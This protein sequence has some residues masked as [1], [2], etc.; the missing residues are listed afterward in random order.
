MMGGRGI[1]FVVVWSFAAMALPALADVPSVAVAVLEP[2]GESKVSGELRFTPVGTEGVRVQGTISGLSGEQAIHIHQ[3]G[4]CRAKDGT[5][6][7]PHFMAPNTHHGAPNNPGSHLGDLGN[8][9]ANK[10]G[11][12]TVDVT[13]ASISLTGEYGVLGRGVI[14]H[15]GKDDLK[16]DP[17]GNSGARVACGIIGAAK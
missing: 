11:V 4:D 2:L 8:L 13:I 5:S 7:G 14:V 16:T 12:A 10:D 6:A 15:A 17:A 1:I 3:F 9:S